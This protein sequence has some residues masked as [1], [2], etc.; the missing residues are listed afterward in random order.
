MPVLA[1]AAITS[2]NIVVLPPPTAAPC[3]ADALTPTASRVAPGP[4]KLGD[5]PDGYLMRTVLRRVDG[6]DVMEVR[7][8]G[9][10]ELKRTGERLQPTPAAP[11]R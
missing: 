11:G 5:L 1:L 8:A 3:K 10:W 7:M 4:R 6:C 9:V 2:L